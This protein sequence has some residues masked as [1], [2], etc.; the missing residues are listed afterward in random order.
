MDRNDLIA[1]PDETA[2][3]RVLANLVTSFLFQPDMTVRGA[4]YHVGMMVLGQRLLNLAGSGRA[5]A[6]FTC[7]NNDVVGAHYNHA[8]APT[9]F[10]S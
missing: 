8:I 10:C 6:H 1:L 3:E 9:I 7:G 4:V 2:I 5:D